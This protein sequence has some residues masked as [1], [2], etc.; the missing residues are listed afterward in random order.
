MSGVQRLRLRTLLCRDVGCL[1]QPAMNLLHQL[2]DEATGAGALSRA[3]FVL[4]ALRVLSVGLV[5][6]DFSEYL[7]SVGMLARASGSSFRPGLSQPTDDCVV[8]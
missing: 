1:G 2:G 4:S 5:R 3:L 8:E 7:A 6:G